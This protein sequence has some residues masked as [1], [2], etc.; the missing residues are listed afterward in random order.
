ME[1]FARLGM[2]T[3]ATE[4]AATWDAVGHPSFV[5]NEWLRK[6]AGVLLDAAAG[7]SVDGAAAVTALLGLRDEAAATGLAFHA[8]WAELDAARISAEHDTLAAVESYRRA[9]Q[10]AEQSGARTL[11]RLAEQGLRGLGARPWRRGPN[12]GAGIG[13]AAL[14]AREREVADL[15]A[16]GA[17]NGEIAD[18]LFLARKTVEHHVSNAMAK[19]GL[20]TRAELAA[21][22]SRSSGQPPPGMG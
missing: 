6:R 10:V 14:S 5:E 16:T 18:R 4:A 2:A 3:E 20:H 19:L 12:S 21:A 22:V 15:V 9:A 8:L 1:V 13:L 7:S 11:Q 17:T